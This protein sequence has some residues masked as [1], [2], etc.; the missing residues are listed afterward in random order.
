MRSTARV[1]AG[2]DKYRSTI[3]QRIHDRSPMDANIG[4]PI[5]LKKH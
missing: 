4:A 3:S 1:S 2:R 5:T